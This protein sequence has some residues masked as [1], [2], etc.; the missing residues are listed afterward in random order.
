MKHHP[1]RLIRLELLTL[2]VTPVAHAVEILRWARLPLAMP[3]IVGQ[4]RIVFVDRNIRVGFPSNVGD[5]LRVQSTDGAIYL[6]AY[7]THRLQLQDADSRTLILLDIAA[8]PAKD[9]EPALEP[10][11]IAEGNTTPPRHGQQ[12]DSETDAPITGQAGAT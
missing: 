5:R 12:L 7:R 3:L 6:R 1:I 11:R 2:M 9:G 8:S 10:V 4:E